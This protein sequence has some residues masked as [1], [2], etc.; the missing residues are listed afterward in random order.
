MKDDSIGPN[1]ADQPLDADDDAPVPDIDQV[2][3]NT[4]RK[5][6]TLL[7]VGAALLLLIHTTPFGAHVRNWDS[8]AELFK[9]GG[10]KAEF[11][12]V[13]ISSFLIMVGTPRLLFCALGGFAFGFWGG[14][15]WSL[16][17]S[18]I[19]SFLA[20][21]AAR[22]GGR[23]W[24]TEHL[25]KRRF[26]S[27]IVH[28]EPTVA[29]VTLIRML[30]VSNG[31]INVGMALSRVDN[32]AFLLGSLLGFLPQGVVAVIIGSGMA[33]DV[34]W[35]GAAQLAVA[36]VL[37]IAVLIWTSRQRRKRP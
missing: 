22:W 12:Y 14:L 8:L 33:E 5:L 1:P 2:A 19:G 4:S 35:M 6:L 32:R 17:S 28:A 34:P 29:S 10:I 16:C 24:L 25:G 7:V 21:R 13:V 23:A 37:L 20:F 31:I 3:R 27:R 30:P 15:F 18:L 9:S 26:F 11:Y 36:G